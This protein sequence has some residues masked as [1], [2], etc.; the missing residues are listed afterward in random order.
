M[1]GSAPKE[2]RDGGAGDG[3]AGDSAESDDRV[4]AAAEELYGGSPDAFT[5]RRAELAT[6]ARVAGDRASAR[7]IGAL[8]RPT[9]A[10]WVV[11]R[12]TRADPSA[13]GQLAELGGG[14]LAAQRAGNGAR[15]R[16]LSAAR[17]ALLDSLTGL[18]F[19]AA[20]VDDPPAGLREEVTAT[21]AAAI[22]DPSVA[23]DLAA[24]VLTK[25]AEWAGFGPMVGESGFGPVAG[26]PGFGA[27][28]GTAAADADVGVPAPPTPGGG[29]AGAGA[30]ARAGAAGRATR[31][32]AVRD[33]PARLPQQAGV[34]VTG[35]RSPGMRTPSRPDRGRSGEAAGEEDT[36][37]RERRAAAE[38]KRLA[39]EA[40]ERAARQRSAFEESERVVAAASAATAEALAAEERLEGDVRDL[41]ERLTKARSDLAA[42]RLRARRAE[43]A[44]R[45][46]RLAHERLPRP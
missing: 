35:A 6:A 17:G 37:A 14:L 40:A 19:S 3:G 28:S 43:A 30:G 29:E 42:A 18:A 16:E 8:R 24:G 20:G 4:A 41:E 36:A 31:S 7:A 2:R 5:A 27:D 1:G 12:L 44:E 9:R 11:N 10:A 15:L 22:A 26:E 32:Q 45:R 21:L 13:A 34:A 38:A 33:M 39:E 46:A 23:A 25:G